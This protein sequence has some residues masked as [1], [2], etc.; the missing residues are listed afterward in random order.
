[1]ARLARIVV[2]GLPHHVTQRGNRREARQE[3]LFIKDND[4]KKIHE[5]LENDLGSE[6]PGLTF[7]G[8]EFHQADDL[9]KPVE[10]VW[11]RGETSGEASIPPS[12]WTHSKWQDTI[13]QAGR[14]NLR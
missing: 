9:A 7:K 13:G 11:I 14:R 6:L 1:M 8:Y 4:L 2:P 12:F 3:R 10:N 5:R